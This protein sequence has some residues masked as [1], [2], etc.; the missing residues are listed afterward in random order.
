MS[1][2]PIDLR[3]YF[4]GELPESSKPKV[5]AHIKTCDNCREELDRL[6]MTQ[7]ALLSLPDEEL[8]QRIRFVSDKVFEPSPF[9]RWLDGFWTSTAKL[10]FASA[11]ILSG[12]LVFSTLHKPATV[13]SDRATPLPAAV[14]S[15][16]QPAD[17]QRQVDEAV[18]RAVAESETRQARKTEALLAEDRRQNELSRQELKLQVKDW[19]DFTEKRLNQARVEL[20]KAEDSWGSR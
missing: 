4:M 11:A 9:R 7:T 19:A 15:Q 12:A 5:I 10:G 16:T 14:V 6:R 3:D 1:C 18:R 17:I 13:T 2:S 8:P 20:A